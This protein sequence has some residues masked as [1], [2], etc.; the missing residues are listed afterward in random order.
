MGFMPASSLLAEVSGFL[1]WFELEL[2]ILSD[3][4]IAAYFRRGTKLVQSTA[5]YIQID[6]RQ[7]THTLPAKQEALLGAGKFLC[8]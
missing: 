3:E 2:L 8:G 1:A 5:G 6:V 4:Q 7:L